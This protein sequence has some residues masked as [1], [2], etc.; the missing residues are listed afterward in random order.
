MK[1]SESQQNIAAE[2]PLDVV[3][4]LV[5]LLEKEP[6][7]GI[8]AAEVQKA[9]SGAILRLASQLEQFCETQKGGEP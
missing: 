5:R 3:E 4:C 2:A 7:N 6:F 1:T 8:P 9:R